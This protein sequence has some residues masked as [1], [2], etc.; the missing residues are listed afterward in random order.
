MTEQ[1]LRDHFAAA[2]LTGLSCGRPEWFTD[3]YV[4]ALSDAAWGLADAMLA[5]R[6]EPQP[7][8]SGAAARPDGDTGGDGP[9][10]GYRWLS[11]PDVL[12]DGD[13]FRCPERGWTRT[14][15][16]GRVAHHGSARQY[17][18]RITT[19][20]DAAP[21]A[22]APQVDAAPL[23]ATAPVTCGEGTGDTRAEAAVTLTDAARPAGDTVGAITLTGAELEVLIECADIAHSQLLSA[24]EGGNEETI[25]RLTRRHNVIRGLHARA[26]SKETET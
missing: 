20:H 7:S 4:K 13:E 26:T 15:E 12:C 17:R 11:P 23:R 25:A 3:I 24:Y 22:R 16:Q 6:G 2:A 10:D 14:A 19:D 21:A 9:G 8:A 1:E 5:A 18:R